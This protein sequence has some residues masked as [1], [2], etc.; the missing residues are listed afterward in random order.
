MTR[1]VAIVRAAVA[2]LNAGDVDGYLR[3]IDPSCQRWVAGLDQPIGVADIRTSIFQLREAFADLF[4]HEDMLFGADEHVCARWRMTGVHV[5]DYM[6]IA[7]QR[8]K[9][10]LPSCEIYAVT[11]AAITTVWTYGDPGQL[12]RQLG[13]AP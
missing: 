13:A 9:I 8:R 3:H 4:L 12:V 6:G 1:P 7:P 5:R 2:A 11:G 10:D